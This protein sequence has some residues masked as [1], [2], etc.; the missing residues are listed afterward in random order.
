M[1]L[2]ATTLLAILATTSAATIKR[3]QQG[4]VVARQVIPERSLSVLSEFYKR[5]D[6]VDIEGLLAE[7][8]AY[9]NKRG[10]V[11]IELM[12]RDYAI[13]TSV[14]SLINQTNLAPQVI[15]YFITSE[16][17]KPI[18]INVT[19]SVI[20]SGIISLTALLEALVE[21]GLAINVINDLI[22]DCELYISLFN[23]AAQIIGN[24]DINVASLISAGVSS[25]ITRDDLQAAAFVES[26]KRD[27]DM[28]EI[29]NRASGIFD[30]IVVEL[31]DSLY[32][33][34]LATSVVQEVLT[35]P[36]YITFATELVV[37]LLEEKLISITAI[38][39]ALVESGLVNQLFSAFL[40]IDTLVTVAQTAFAA[41]SGDCG[42]TIDIG[43]VSTD[44]TTDTTSNEPAVAPDTEPSTGDDSTSGDSTGGSSSS[45]SGHSNSKSTTKKVVSK[46]VVSSPCKRS[47]IYY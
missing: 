1:Q 40:N 36:A 26:E 6:E 42:V 31:L 37:R 27:D 4:D 46:Q 25:L 28:G 7:I 47:N 16:T 12:E 44:T 32:V 30:T 39:S 43:T 15:T 10:E 35:N 14:F 18:V 19:V 9:R 22:G 11:D 20:K 38:I 29:D 8:N 5:G 3:A 13:V 24:L 23:I 33:S 21:S 45:S 17:F 2:P 41:F 34:G